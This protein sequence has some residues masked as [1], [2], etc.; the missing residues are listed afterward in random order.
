MLVTLWLAGGGTLAATM[1]FS[2]AVITPYRTIWAWISFIGMV[3]LE[4]VIASHHHAGWGWRLPRVTLVAA[5]IV[6]RKHPDTTV[7]VALSAALLASLVMT[8][9]WQ[10]V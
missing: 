3:A 5:I 7:L 4:D 2:I 9:D 6:F 1:A 8:G 10:P